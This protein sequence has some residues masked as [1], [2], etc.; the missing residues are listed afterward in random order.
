MAAPP[1]FNQY[2][3]MTLL[4]TSA[5][6]LAA[7]NAQGCTSID[8]MA[9]MTD[10]DVKDIC[11][12]I[13]KPG[14]VI[15]NRVWTDAAVAQRANIPRYI[16]NP[17]I[18]VGHLH[19]KR[20]RML[21]YYV[22]HLNRVQRAFVAAE[23]TLDQLATVYKIKEVEDEDDEKLTLPIKLTTLETVRET[24]ED[25]D[26]YF[27]RKKGSYKAPLA[28][29]TREDVALPAVGDDPG[30]GRPS[31]YQEMIIRS[32]HIGTYYNLDNNE[33]FYS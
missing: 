21:R 16:P 24:L 28:Y 13:K 15:E 33:Y 17:G 29:V 32:P 31:F 14:G 12:N 5:A 23:A 7:I 10:T 25:L 27:L 19:E 11:N 4:I 22:W 1:T 2:L 26:N 20:L 8:D 18:S 3:S 6:T 30:F 9:A